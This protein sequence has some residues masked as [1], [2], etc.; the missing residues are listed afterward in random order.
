M[1]I[2]SFLELDLK[3][4]GE[5]FKTDGKDIAR[6]NSG[7]SAILHSIRLL[8]CSSVYIPFYLCPEVKQFL[9]SKGINVH[10]YSISDNFAPLMDRNETDTAMLIVN[11]YGLFDGNKLISIKEKY[12]NV[13]IDNC[14]AFFA[15]A[16]PGCFSVFSCR[17]FFGVPDGSYA[18]GHNASSGCDSYPLDESADTSS[19]LLKRIEKGCS[20]VYEERML[21]EERINKSDIRRM[22]LLTQSLMNSLDFEWIR[23]RRIENFKYA[24]ELFQEKNL[25]NVG[26]FIEKESIPLFYP[27]VL[28]NR[29]IVGEL[30]KKGIYTGRRWISVLN[31]TNPDSFEYF[32]SEYMVPIPVDQRYAKSEILYIYNCIIEIL[33]SRS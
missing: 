25:L 5:Y 12:V 11:H 27:L 7:R 13:I 1:E 28:K 8:N 31:S 33:A 9:V 21:N 29:E 19:F 4:T 24:V 20:P 3:R 17:K 15:P 10:S 22:S 2:G 23:N 26:S 32:L 14:S 16:L 30:K 6:L 18:I